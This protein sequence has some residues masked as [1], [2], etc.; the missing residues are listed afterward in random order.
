[1]LRLAFRRRE[2]TQPFP[3]ERHSGQRAEERKPAARSTT[4]EIANADALKAAC[5]LG[6][7]QVTSDDGAEDESG[8][9]ASNVS[10]I[11][12]AGFEVAVSEDRDCRRDQAG[13]DRPRDMAR[14]ADFI[15]IQ[16]RDKRANDAEDGARRSRAGDGWIP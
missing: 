2:P 15:E 8:D 7:L 1:M 3:E 14:D 12:D 6:A 16:C 10:A 11:I 9:Q 4:A 13:K 5:L